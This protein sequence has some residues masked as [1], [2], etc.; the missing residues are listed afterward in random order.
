[1][2]GCYKGK[3]KMGE[4]GSTVSQCA[5]MVLCGLDVPP[6]PTQDSK[7]SPRYSHLSEFQD[8]ERGLDAPCRFLP[9]YVWE[10]P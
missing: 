2:S 9:S 6:F 3:G 8:S 1:M 7:P 10:T 5:S 4:V